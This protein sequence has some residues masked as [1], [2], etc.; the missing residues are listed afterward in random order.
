MRKVVAGIVSLLAMSVAGCGGTSAVFV[1]TV[2]SVVPS[3]TGVPNSV[4]SLWPYA[5][6]SVQGTGQIF[7]YNISSGSQVQVGAPYAT[8][9]ASPSGMVIGNIAGA[10]VMAVPC[11]DKGTLLT[12]SV[13]ADGSLSA[14]GAVGGLP[15][16]YPGIALDG[17]NVLVP[18]F[19]VVGASN[20]SVAKVSIASPANP[21]VLGVTPLASPASGGFVNAGFLTVS[22][23]KIFVAA[24]SESAPIDT[25][26]SVQVVDEATMTLVGKPLVVAHS[27]Q[28]LAVQN[29]VAFVTF[30]DAAQF[31]SVDVS[32]PAN[33]KPL[34]KLPMAGVIPNCQSI[35]ILVRGGMAYVGCY[36]EGTVY[37][38]DVSNP[39]SMV[40]SETISG[41]DYPQE[42]NVADRYLLVTDSA[43]GGRVYQIDTGVTISG[44]L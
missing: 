1:P 21:V 5:F 7:T 2:T 4:A 29:G 10:S 36:E 39:S 20:G 19:G 32:D 9:C 17:T 44:K 22:N 41:I 26:S 12:L 16:P 6:V 18:L 43:R 38:M 30:Y 31:E 27:P 8:P 40:L 34:Q 28:H 42:F 33:L 35:P 15:V 11:W 13:H 14:L 23:G 25:S 37:K 24:G 3:S